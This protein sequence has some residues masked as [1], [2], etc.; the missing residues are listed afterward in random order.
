MSD[1]YENFI[2]EYGIFNKDISKWDVSNVTNMSG[3]FF[4]CSYFAQD[5]SSWDVSKVTDMSQMFLATP[6]LNQDIGSW[7]VG[8][9]TNMSGMFAHNQTLP[10]NLKIGML[11]RLLICQ[12]C[13]GELQMQVYLDLQVILQPRMK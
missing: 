5:I 6:A 13:F 12:E 1:I 10:L 4:G 11:V 2:S 7:D 8:N 3:M 9:V